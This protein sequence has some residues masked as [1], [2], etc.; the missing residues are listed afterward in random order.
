MPTKKCD[1]ESDS[2]PV[3][4][5]W[6]DIVYAGE[7]IEHL[8]DTDRFLAESRRALKFSDFLLPT[9]RAQELLGKGARDRILHQAVSVSASF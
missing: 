8:V 6:A 7:V 5:A 4:P 1:L 9:R 2:F 3:D